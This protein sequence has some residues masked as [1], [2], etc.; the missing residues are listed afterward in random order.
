MKIH[1]YPLYPFL[2]SFPH[3]STQP[4]SLFAS[5]VCLMGNLCIISFLSLLEHLHFMAQTDQSQRYTYSATPQPLLLNHC[6]L[7]LTPG[8]ISP[9]ETNLLT[10]PW[11]VVNTSFMPR[12]LPTP[13]YVPNR[14]PVHVAL[15]ITSRPPSWCCVGSHS[16][17]LDR[18]PSERK[19][20]FINCGSAYMLGKVKQCHRLLVR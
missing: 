16:L 11:A 19:F 5:S 1:A 10:T 7:T 18:I 15:N 14:C 17:F 4:P 3:P 8:C 12:I 20:H 9:A 6:H 13:P 2:A